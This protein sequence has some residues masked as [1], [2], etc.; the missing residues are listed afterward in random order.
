MAIQTTTVLPPSIP[1]SQKGIIQVEGGAVTIAKIAVPEPAPDEILV[2]NAVI[3]C[4]PCDIKVPNM[5]PV[6]GLV[7]GCDFAGTV[8]AVGHE[9]TNHFRV[10]DRVFGAVDGNKTGDPL[11]GAYCEYVK[12]EHQYILKIPAGLSFQEGAAI[13]GTA[14]ATTGLALHWSLAIEGSLEKPAKN[15]PEEAIFIHG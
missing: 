4:N 3:A 10:G 6:P 5:N 15:D 9:A 12:A 11:S 13:P 7:N 2:H 14:I 8:V 1:T